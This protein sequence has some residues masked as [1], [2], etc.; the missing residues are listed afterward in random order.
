MRTT[1][2]IDDAIAKALKDLAHRSNKP[3]KQV[4]NE[5]LRAGLSAPAASKSRRYR[6]KP[7]A[8]GGVLPGITWTRRWRSPTRSRI[9]SSRAKCSC[10]SDPRRRQPF[11]L[12]GRFRFAAAH[13]GATRLPTWTPGCGNH[14][15]DHRSR[16]AALADP[17][18]PAGGHRDR[19]Q[20]HLGCPPR[21]AGPGTRRAYVCSTDHDFARFPGIRHVNP[22]TAR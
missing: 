8:L 13:A 10:A 20:S 15:S 11:D 9:R 19:R 2:T 17:A 7:A 21:G 3:F 14:A 22:L 4:V 5:T 16:R 12:R 6:V 18:P 1:L